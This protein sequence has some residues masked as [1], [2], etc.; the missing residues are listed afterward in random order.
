[1]R[2]IIECSESYGF[3]YSMLRGHWRG[4]GLPPEAAEWK[5]IEIVEHFRGQQSKVEA[6]ASGLHWRLGAE[7]M[8]SQL[9]EQVLVPIADEV[10]GGWSLMREWRGEEGGHQKREA[11]KP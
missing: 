10:L 9:D 11:E 5:D 3:D 6:F 1:M 7:S 4:L 2:P 8:L